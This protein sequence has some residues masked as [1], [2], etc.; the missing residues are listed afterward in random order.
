MQYDTDKNRS[1]GRRAHLIDARN[2]RVC[3][4]AETRA[5][6]MDYT[7][8]GC[9]KGYRIATDEG[10]GAAEALWQAIMRHDKNNGKSR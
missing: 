8:D 5:T 7:R 10:Y 9:G 1:G 4:V 3:S 6:R 2:D